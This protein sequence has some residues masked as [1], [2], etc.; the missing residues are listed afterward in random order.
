M[1][2]DPRNN[3]NDYEKLTD[4]EILD[5]VRKAIS[6]T[7]EFQE[8]RNSPL[9]NTFKG[10]SL[11][12][13][14]QNC[15]NELVEKKKLDKLKREKRLK[16]SIIPIDDMRKILKDYYN[17][18]DRI[19]SGIKTEILSNVVKRMR[20]TLYNP[21]ENVVFNK[22]LDLIS[23]VYEGICSLDKLKEIKNSNKYN[24]RGLGPFIS[25]TIETDDTYLLSPTDMDELIELNELQR[26]RCYLYCR[27]SSELNIMKD[28]TR[29][30][31][32]LAVS[33]INKFMEELDK[34]SYKN[35]TNGNNLENVT[36]KSLLDEFNEGYKKA[37][38]KCNIGVDEVCRRT[39]NDDAFDTEGKYVVDFVKEFVSNNRRA[40]A[41]LIDIE[42]LNEI[43]KILNKYA[44]DFDNMTDEEFMV[45]K[46]RQ[47]HLTEEEIETFEVKV[48]EILESIEISKGK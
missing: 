27:L 43:R 7:K 36:K 5:S 3:L 23:K 13:V 48:E 19:H 1:A 33:E 6:I 14:I 38:E 22:H 45:Y 30:R 20:L 46:L 35:I 42:S 40:E 28:R 34:R 47:M 15:M 24:Y 26:E 10:F 29:D 4:E 39:V 37:Q 9:P 32:L 11:G 25:S 18:A 8:G 21:L 16:R 31:Y 2:E 17:N 44:C 12:I 41:S